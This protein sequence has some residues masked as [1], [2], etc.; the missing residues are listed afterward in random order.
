MVSLP[1][2]EDETITATAR[3]TPNL[4]ALPALE[5]VGALKQFRK[6]ES[7]KKPFWKRGERQP[8]EMTVAVD[9]MNITVPRGEI[10]GLL[11]ANGS[12]KSTLIR[13]VSTLLIPDGG[14]IRVFGR[15][16][17]NEERAVRRMINRVSVEASFF[18][19]LSALENLMYAAR[20]YDMPIVAARARAIYILG[21]LGMKEKRL[22]E[23]LENMSRGM[24]QKIAIARGLLTSPVLLLLDEPTT[25]LDPRS[26]QDVQ[27]FILR[28]RREHETTVFL[29]T[30]DMDEADRL[31][32]RIA[33][34]DDGKIVA[35]DTPAELKRQL[36]AQSGK[37]GS[38]TMEEVFLA[39]TGKSLD[40]DFEVEGD[41]V[42]EEE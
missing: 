21:Q 36:G 24:Q 29:T 4:D 19:K 6:D 10:F 38:T 34:I 28:M 27:R 9:H 30:H 3:P 14:E 1:T 32:D 26:K 35:L 11:G 13:L 12:G 39:L 5:I 37:N 7:Q 40:D 22:Y 20:L 15:D 8:R 17:Q 23:P 33:V 18:K 41:A 31:C 16:V 2:L 25:G 42:A